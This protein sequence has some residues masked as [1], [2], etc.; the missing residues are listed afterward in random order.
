[1]AVNS[2]HHAGVKVRLQNN[3]TQTMS[4]V[5]QDTSTAA[6]TGRELY[7]GRA[8][9][10]HTV[11]I[12][13][14][15]PES[16]TDFD[17]SSRP[18]FHR[19]E[20]LAANAGQEPAPGSREDWTAMQAFNVKDEHTMT[21]TSQDAVQNLVYWK[22]EDGFYDQSMSTDFCPAQGQAIS[23]RLEDSEDLFPEQDQV[24]HNWQVNHESAPTST[25]P[26]QFL[27]YHPNVGMNHPMAA[28]MA[29]GSLAM[30]QWGM[31]QT[32]G[33]STVNLN[34]IDGGTFHQMNSFPA[35][36]ISN[37]S[38]FNDEDDQVAL[39]HS[40]LPFSLESCGLY[41]DGTLATSTSAP[42]DTMS[43]SFTTTP[44]PTSWEVNTPSYSAPSENENEN[45]AKVHRQRRPRPIMYRPSGK[46]EALLEYKRQG[47]SYK[48]IK[49]LGNFEEAESTLRGRYRTLTKPK[50]E[51]V[52]KPQWKTRDVSKE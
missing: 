31:H 11:H 5:P 47:F 8:G 25:I 23:N 44:A 34:A 40:G 26:P 38:A 29:H 3:Q 36:V 48:Q 14:D 9:D 22:T 20:S 28:L 51:R 42:S 18:S 17:H 21:T 19:S 39:Y 2:H 30:D 1:L 4:D 52:R 24:L 7:G 35:T 16:T 45:E 10:N 37:A 50:E 41:F 43:N 27:A 12:T 32:G 49:V 33:N 46:D 13:S 6:C 15:L